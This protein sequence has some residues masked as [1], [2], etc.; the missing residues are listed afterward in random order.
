[1]TAAAIA[2]ALGASATQGS[3]N[4]LS[5]KIAPVNRTAA[6][7]SERTSIGLHLRL[8]PSSC[9]G[10]PMV[11]NMPQR[12]PEQA[13]HISWIA[14]AGGKTPEQQ[15]RTIGHLPMPGPGLASAAKRYACGRTAMNTETISNF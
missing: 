10:L 4:V 9:R 11:Q 15:N 2:D 14:V 3:W 6:S 7:T 1:M 12:A 13:A 8:I 5:K